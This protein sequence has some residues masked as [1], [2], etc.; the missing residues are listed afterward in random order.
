MTDAHDLMVVGGGSGLALERPVHT[1]EEE[2]RQFLHKLCEF[3]KLYGFTTREPFVDNRKLSLR[4]LY[5]AVQECQ[6]R[7]CLRAWAVLRSALNGCVC[8]GL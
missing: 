3:N 1:R 5:M 2:D 8:A 6:V 7:L 4:A